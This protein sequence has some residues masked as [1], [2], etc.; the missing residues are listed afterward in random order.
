MEKSIKLKEK[1]HNKI[2]NKK[3]KHLNYKLISQICYN[4]T[5]AKNS[6][7]RKSI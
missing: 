7:Q 3:L 1:K 6:Q 5:N 4:Q 2:K